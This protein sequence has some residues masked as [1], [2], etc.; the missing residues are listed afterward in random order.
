LAGE[1]GKDV[2]GAWSL[3][4][5]IPGS[6]V[7]LTMK[8]A[9]G[10]SRWVWSTD[11]P[12]SDLRGLTREQL[13]SASATVKFTME[14]DAGTF[15]FEGSMMLGLGSGD[16]RFRPDPTFTDKLVALGYEA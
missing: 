4:N 3:N 10:S 13:R 8:H 11:H 14:R 6:S 9:S 7:H 2:K 1:G 12:V 16:F 5:W 15:E